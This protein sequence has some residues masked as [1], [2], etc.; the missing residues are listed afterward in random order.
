MRLDAPVPLCCATYTPVAVRS[1]KP[2]H[3]HANT[4]IFNVIF[5]GQRH[6]PLPVPG[7]ALSAR[8]RYILQRCHRQRIRHKEADYGFHGR[9]CILYALPHC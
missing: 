9:F 5:H 3:I 6:M 2:L 7:L 8:A 1:A 4:L